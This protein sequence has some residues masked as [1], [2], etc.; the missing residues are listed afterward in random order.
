MKSTPLLCVLLAAIPLFAHAKHPRDR[1]E[2]RAFRLENPCPS[3]G[4]VKGACPGWHAG[5]IVELC[6]G[7]RDTRDNM[8]WITEADRQFVKNV[9]GK[10]CRKLKRGA[11][12]P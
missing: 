5:Y 8:R 3:N 6:A 7:G 9:N 11:L 2:L 1:E 10:N 12:P 4:T